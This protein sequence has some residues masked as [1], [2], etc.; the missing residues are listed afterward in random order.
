MDAR[1]LTGD[2]IRT[3]GDNAWLAAHANRYGDLYTASWYEHLAINGRIFVSNGGTGTTPVT[4]GAGSIDTTE[5]DIDIQ[6]ANTI[7]V[8]PLYIAFQMETFG[9]NA[10]FEGMASSGLGGVQ[11]TTTTQLTPR[12]LRTDN[13]YASLATVWTATDGSGSTYMTTNIAEFW[14]FG[15]EAVATVGTGD[16]DSNRWGAQ[17]IWQRE[18]SQMRP[19]LRASATLNPRAVAFAGSQAGTGFVSL[20]HAELPSDMIG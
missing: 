9:T 2:A 10:L 12:N 1:F 19:V 8:L 6:G 7:V 13:P 17:W 15:I 18:T 20:G 14:R 16:D 5:P 4:F 3:D 11:G